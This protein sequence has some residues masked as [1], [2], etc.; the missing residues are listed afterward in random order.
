MSSQPLKK[1]F[2]HGNS[3]LKRRQILTVQFVK[4][5]FIVQNIYSAHEKIKDEKIKR[6]KKIKIA[7][8]RNLR[9]M[10]L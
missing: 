9:S 2:V 8:Q 3:L 7:K 6:M 4:K 1:H 10:N 5:I